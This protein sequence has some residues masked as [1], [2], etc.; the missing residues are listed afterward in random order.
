MPNIKNNDHIEAMLA[1]L[2]PE[3]YERLVVAVETGKW[4]DGVALTEEQKSNTL[5]LVMLWQAKHNHDAQHMTI[6]TKGE[7]VIE[8]KKELKKR[9]AGEEI[10]VVV[11]DNKN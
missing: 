5:Q 6:N 11:E 4:A 3:I 8:S 10:Q 2:T 7:M 9:F 1:S